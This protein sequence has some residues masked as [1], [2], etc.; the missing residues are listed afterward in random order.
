MTRSILPARPQAIW[1]S[2]ATRLLLGTVFVPANLPAMAWAQSEAPRQSYNIP[3]QPLATA[4][5][6]FMH[7]SGVQVSFGTDAASARSGAVEGHLTAN[8]A[9]AQL[10]SG[11]GLTHRYAAETSVI[12]EPAPEARGAI[13]LGTV[14][15]VGDAAAGAGPGGSEE[16]SASA[17]VEG[18]VAKRTTSGTKT[19]GY[20]VETPQSV[21]VVTAGQIEVQAAQTISEA[22]RYTAGIDA[23]AFGYDARLSHFTIRGFQADNA[24][25]LD[26]LRLPNGGYAY[27][28]VETYGLERVEVLRGPTSGLYGQ[29]VPGGLVNMISKLPTFARVA[30]VAL[31]TGDPSRRQGAFDFGNAVGDDGKLAFRVT[32]LARQADTQNDFTQDNRQFLAPALTWRPTPETEIILLGHIQRDRVE[33]WSGTFLPASGTLLAN[34]NGRLPIRRFVGEPGYDHLYRDQYAVGYIATHQLAPNLTLRSR[35]R[36]TDLDVDAPNIFPSALGA[37]NRTLTR[38]Q[39]RFRD[40]VRGWSTDNS[41]E[42][43]FVGEAIEHHL[44]AG[45]DYRWTKDRDRFDLHFGGVAPLDIYAP[46]YGSAT[47]PLTNLTDNEQTQRHAGVYVQDQIRVSDWIVTLGGRYDAFRAKTLAVPTGAITRQSDEA[48]TGRIAIGYALSPGVVPYLSY[49]TSFEP[50]AGTTFDGAP[51]EPTT[52]RQIEAGLKYEP[53]AF[54]GLFTAAVYELTQQ[55]VLSDDPDPTH[56]Y[57]SIQEGEVRVRGVELEGKAEVSAKW[58]VLA[59]YTYSDAEITRSTSVANGAPVEGTRAPIIPQHQASVWSD[60]TLT[61]GLTLGGGLR[62]RGEI[63]GDNTKAMRVPAYTLADAAVRYDLSSLGDGF[64]GL[65]LSVNGSNIFGKEY[66]AN[67]QTGVCYFG[68]A[69]SVLLTLGYR[70]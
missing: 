36:Y 39:L 59:S 68:L 12:L 14:R 48:I 5:R 47:G 44:L 23:E 22:L 45:F 50:Q 15:V 63:Y 70:W 33:G 24:Q 42:G 13:Q 4:V 20:I 28:R 40:Y 51:F 38:S 61:N 29:N 8:E 57:A 60:Y 17:R 32:G 49:S 55:N 3:A 66:V 30:E 52:G 65:S 21:S 56:P 16:A 19:D 34:P 62:Y 18:Y 26:G 35:A 43:R 58:S 1:R 31:Q 2:L 54:K 11:T 25:F 7:Q 53:M 9:L 6:Q 41:V 37:D 46:V 64:K 67:C 27:A 69:R 10:L